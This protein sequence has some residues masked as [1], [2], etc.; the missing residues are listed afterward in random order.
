MALE[1]HQATQAIIDP[2]FLPTSTPLN[3]SAWKLCLQ[4][5]PDRSF[6]EFILKGVSTGFRIGFSR[7]SPLSSANKNLASTL[8]HVAVVDRYLQEE[9]QLGHVLGPFKP[10]DLHHNIHISPIGI[11]PKRH[12]ANKWRLVVDMS[13]PEG[14]SLN[15]GIA[16]SLASLEYIRIEDVIKEIIVSGPRALLAKIDI[17]IAY[18][19]CPVHPDDRPLLGMSFQGMTY[20]DAALP[21]GLRSAPKI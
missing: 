10:A 2:R 19:I 16:P 7:S 1:T 13:A 20:I 17:K 5:H 11:I 8:D 3:T 15:D 18:R 21:F 6:A 4:S 12:Q 9:V 14:S